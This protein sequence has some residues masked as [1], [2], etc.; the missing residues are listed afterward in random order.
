MH[1]VNNIHIKDRVPAASAW[2]VITMTK[3]AHKG[4]FKFERNLR[5]SVN[6]KNV[7]DLNIAIKLK[8]FKIFS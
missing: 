5:K 6:N 1:K 4:S 3:T 7:I 8:I 2:S